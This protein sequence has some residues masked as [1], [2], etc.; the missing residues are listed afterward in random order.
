MKNSCRESRSGQRQSSGGFQS[1]AWKKPLV[2]SIASDQGLSW[3]PK[4]NTP[5]PCLL[6]AGTDSGNAF[7]LDIRFPCSV[8]VSLNRKM[9]HQCSRHSGQDRSIAHQLLFWISNQEHHI[10]NNQSESQHSGGPPR[11]LEC[12]IRTP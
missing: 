6:C 9:N 3:G 8:D 7:S 11:I 10:L 2:L 4:Q 12:K 1:M 5:P